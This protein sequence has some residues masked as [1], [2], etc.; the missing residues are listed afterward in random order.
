[1]CSLY[2]LLKKI[3]KQPLIY[4][5]EKNLRFLRAFIDGYL[6]CED[7]RGDYESMEAFSGLKKYIEDFYNSQTVHDYCSLITMHSKSN[8]EAFDCFFEHFDI[9]FSKYIESMQ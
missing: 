7:E 4:L 6:E 5:G 1:M 3:E 9:F 8:E 2:L